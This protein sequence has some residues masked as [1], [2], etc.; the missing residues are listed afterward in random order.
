LVSFNK[1]LITAPPWFPVAPVT[2]MT[3]DMVVSRD[4]G[5]EGDMKWVE[6]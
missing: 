6:V 3:L 2:R 4:V 1:A 5:G